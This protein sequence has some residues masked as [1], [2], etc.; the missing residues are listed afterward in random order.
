MQNEMINFV[1]PGIALHNSHKILLVSF[2]PRFGCS[3]QIKKK[4]EG[5]F[6]EAR[7]NFSRIANRAVDQRRMEENIL[8]YFTNSETDLRHSLRGFDYEK[9]AK[10]LKSSGKRQTC[11][12]HYF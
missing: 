2:K 11:A 1:W 5:C 8:K 12:K 10:S 3:K 6:A 4:V 9:H 7:V